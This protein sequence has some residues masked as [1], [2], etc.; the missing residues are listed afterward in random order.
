MVT[1]QQYWSL[2]GRCRGE[3]DPEVYVPACKKRDRALKSLGLHKAREF[4]RAW[5]HGKRKVIRR[6]VQDNLYLP[7]FRGRATGKREC[8]YDESVPRVFCWMKPRGRNW[9]GVAFEVTRYQRPRLPRWQV[10]SAAPDV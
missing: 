9:I 2:E 7:Y 10:V 8:A 6:I 3:S 1:A 5:K 4:H